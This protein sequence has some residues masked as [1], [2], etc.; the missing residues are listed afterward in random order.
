MAT[1]TPFGKELR[2]L[3]LDRGET[4]ASMAG[5]LGRSA[6]FLS[7]VET[8]RKPVPAKLVDEVVGCYSLGEA[9]AAKLH[10]LAQTSTGVF[11]LSP[12]DDKAYALASAFARKFDSLSDDQQNKIL[13]ILGEE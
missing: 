12:L 7:S 13:N 5:K 10:Q 1:P 11:K 2:M 3:R 8:G 6:G 9:T 4:M